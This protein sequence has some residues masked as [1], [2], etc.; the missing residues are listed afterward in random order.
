MMVV[1]F[2]QNVLLLIAA[3]KF[4]TETNSPRV[5]IGSS[6]AGLCARLRKLDASEGT[7]KT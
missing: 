1:L 5:G 4:N 2:L 7:Y 3:E 6:P